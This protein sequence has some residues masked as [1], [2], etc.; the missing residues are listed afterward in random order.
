MQEAMAEIEMTFRGIPE[1]VRVFQQYEHD[2]RY[3]NRYRWNPYTTKEKYER[4]RD[5]LF[6][7]AKSLDHRDLLILYYIQNTDGL[8]AERALHILRGF[9]RAQCRF[10]NKVC[11]KVEYVDILEIGR[12]LGLKKL[13]KSEKSS[14]I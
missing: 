8:G 9:Y 11:G 5:A 6:E 3:Y 12:C 2:L 14:E 1:F 7:I 13:P 10:Q 4:K